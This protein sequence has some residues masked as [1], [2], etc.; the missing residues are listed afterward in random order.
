MMGKHDYCTNVSVIT[1]E[2]LEDVEIFGQYTS[3]YRE[4][5]KLIDVI[6]NKK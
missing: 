2:I 1:P 4:F 5:G 6:F 3:F